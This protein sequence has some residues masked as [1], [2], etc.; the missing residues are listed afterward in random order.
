[1]TE[2]ILYFNGQSWTGMVLTPIIAVLPAFG[3]LMALGGTA[4]ALIHTV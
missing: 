3:L 1:M 4:A 2:P